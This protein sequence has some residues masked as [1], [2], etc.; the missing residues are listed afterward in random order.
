MNVNATASTSLSSRDTLGLAILRVVLGIVFLAHGAQ[1]LFDFGLGGTAEAFAGMGVPL[2]S[3]T[4][5]AVAFVEFFAG[6]ALILGLFT[7]WAALGVGI[8]MAGAIAFVHAP[9]GFF[10]PNGIEFPLTLLAAA[11]ALFLAGPGAYSVDAKRAG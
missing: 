7:R 4:G 9:N 2:A 10:A 6:A 8:V 11:A 5:P 1:K 3:I